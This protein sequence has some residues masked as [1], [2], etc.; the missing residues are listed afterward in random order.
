MNLAG[1]ISGFGHIQGAEAPENL[2]TS[3]I[4]PILMTLEL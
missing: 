3:Q 1:V 4:T 2:N